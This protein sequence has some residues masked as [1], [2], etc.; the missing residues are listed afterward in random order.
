MSNKKFTPLKKLA[1][2]ME[3]YIYFVLLNSVLICLDIDVIFTYLLF[4][5]CLI[6]KLAARIFF[7]KIFFYAQLGSQD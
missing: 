1:K 6:D 5:L 3:K 2:Y 7:L 4:N